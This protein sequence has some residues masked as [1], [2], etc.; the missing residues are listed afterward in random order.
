[1]KYQHPRQIYLL[2]PDLGILARYLFSF[3]CCPRPYSYVDPAGVAYPTTAILTDVGGRAS[4]VPNAA[5]SVE[6]DL[7]LFNEGAPPVNLQLWSTQGAWSQCGVSG[8]L[9]D[10]G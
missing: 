9:L 6:L 8:E 10:M 4:S 1:M 2:V 5:A 3:C 7:A